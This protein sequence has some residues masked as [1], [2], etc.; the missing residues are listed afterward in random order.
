MPYNYGDHPPEAG[1]AV[2]API[3]LLWLS[4]FTMLAQT[5]FKQPWQQRLPLNWSALCA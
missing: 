5:G 1:V 3:R 4:P 2:N